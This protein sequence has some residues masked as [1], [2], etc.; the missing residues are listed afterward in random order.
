M[1]DQER[2]FAWVRS[3]Y[4]V[5]TA[6]LIATLVG[7]GYFASTSSGSFGPYN[8][9]WDGVSTLRGEATAVGADPTV[10]RTVDGYG[11]VNAKRSVAVVLSPDQAYTADEADRLEL[12]V[13]G[14][15]TAIVAEDR[16]P[17]G[18]EL[19]REIGAEARVDG[20]VLRD[21]RYHY[22]APALPIAR[23]VTDHPT[24]D[25][26]DRL[27]LNYGTAVRPHGATVLAR[28][29]EYAYLDANANGRLDEDEQLRRY[30]IATIEQLGD[31]R[32]IVLGDPS[33]AINAMVERGGNR[34]FLRNVFGEYETVALD[35]SH[36]RDLPPLRVALLVLQR[37]PLLQLVVGLFGIG[38]IAVVGA[39]VR[40]TE[41]RDGG[42]SRRSLVDV[43]EVRAYL[44][45]EHPEWDEQRIDRVAKG[46]LPGRENE[47][48]ER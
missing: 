18:N 17:H 14:G 27:T 45:T 2:P 41:R 26:V 24:T 1:T 34:R 5:L 20:S 25:G 36:A 38:L 3:P 7:G 44:A 15:G 35:Y 11:T 40:D 23:N 28:T 30:P 31:G 33:V 19:L 43:E 6:L 12:F 8:T 10:F 21:E 13:R 22:R 16:G 9:G 32:V 46:V 4:V 42:D 39:R 29:S 37:S 48:H 47:E